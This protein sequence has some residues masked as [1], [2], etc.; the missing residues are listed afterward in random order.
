MRINDRD[1]KDIA[2]F[3]FRKR[4]YVAFANMVRLYPR[5]PYAFVRYLL[6]RGSYP[7]KIKIRTPLGM[8]SP[9]LYSY[10]DL[11]TVNEIFCRQDYKASRDVKAVVDIGSNIGISALYFLTRNKEARCY[12]FEPAPANIA[13]LEKNLEAFAGRFVLRQAAVADQAGA[14]DFGVEPTGRYGGLGVRTPTVI[15][16]QCLHINDVLKQ[17]LQTEPRVDIL[18]MD[19]EGAEVATV[20][21]IDEKY[22]PKIATLYYET[23]S[24]SVECLTPARQSAS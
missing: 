18:K 15:Q 24:G 6:N 2:T 11:L 20:N 21:A 10:H 8:V 4:N 13:K 22:L 14:L 19:I 23:G 16:V 12:L 5:F 17:V 7:Y 3:L 1:L 9:T